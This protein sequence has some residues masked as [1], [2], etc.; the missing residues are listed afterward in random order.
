MI[1]EASAVIFLGYNNR[2]CV[3]NTT[4]LAFGSY[5]CYDYPE[6][7]L[8][9]EALCECESKVW[10]GDGKRQMPH[11]VLLSQWVLQQSQPHLLLK[12]LPTLDVSELLQ[13]QHI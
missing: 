7:G 3:V 6:V 2:S 5:D 13:A 9:S 10:G 8:A 1:V 4:S 11:K 12:K